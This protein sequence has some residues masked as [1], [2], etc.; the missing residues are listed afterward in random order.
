VIALE[1]LDQ[2]VRPRQAAGRMLGSSAKRVLDRVA[3]LR[4]KRAA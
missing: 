4:A 1:L 2:V 3:E